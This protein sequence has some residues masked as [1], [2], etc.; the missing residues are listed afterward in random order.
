MMARTSAMSSPGSMTM[1]SR[2]ISSPM[3]EQLHCKGPTGEDFVD[4]GK[5]ALSY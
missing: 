5:A 1:A 2:E 4:H 3:I